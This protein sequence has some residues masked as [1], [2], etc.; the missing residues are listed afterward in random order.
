ME[1]NIQRNIHQ[2]LYNKDFGLQRNKNKYKQN[3]Y[4]KTYIN[5]IYKK[6]LNIKF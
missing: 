2:W 3:T 6:K 1:I 4:V 5:T